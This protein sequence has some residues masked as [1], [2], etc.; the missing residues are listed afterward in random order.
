M[1]E[2]YRLRHPVHVLV[3]PFNVGRDRWCGH[4]VYACM[5][6]LLDADYVAF[7]DED[8]FV[9]ADHY[10]HLQK[11]LE[12]NNLHWTFSLRKILDTD[13]QFLVND[14]CESLGNFC[15]TALGWNDFLVDTSCYYLRTEVA[16]AM[17]QRWMHRTTG[18]SRT[19][20]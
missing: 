8:N 6:F 7:L 17:A 20:S 9:D 15:H 4:R 14:N 3:L 19:S 13:G 11:L 5:P 1:V 12:T 2:P 18:P 16:R 10:E